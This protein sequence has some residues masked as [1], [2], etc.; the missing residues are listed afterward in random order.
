MRK[1]LSSAIVLFAIAPSIAQAACPARVG[2][3]YGD[4]LQSIASACGVNVEA[5]KQ[6]NPGLRPETLQAGTYIAVPKPVLLTP[7]PVIG[8]PSIQTFPSLVG[9]ATGG[10]SRSTVILPPQP[11]PVPQ[12]HILRGFGNQPGQLPLP[13][14]HADPFNDFPFMNP[15]HQR[16]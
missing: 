7:P 15:A 13:P 3:S 5:L 8:R 14:G 1:L 11:T 12:Q 9:P 6:A 16:N 10:D 2:V 4:T